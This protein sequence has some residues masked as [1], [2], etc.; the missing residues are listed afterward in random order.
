[1]KKITIGARGSKL[2]LAYVEK[3][4]NLILEKSKDLNDDDFVIKTI[5]TSGD[6]HSD[7]KLSEI[8][9][10]NL[11][12]K[13][14]EENLLEN[15][16][17]IAVHSLKDMESEQNESLMIGAY[18]K[19]NDPRDVL[20]CNKIQNFNELS[21]GAKIGSSSRRRE[22]QLKKINK[23]VSVLNIRGNIDT[24][25]QKIEDQKLDAIVLAAAGVKSLNLENKIGLVF[26]VNEILPAVGQG[27]IAVQCRKDDGPIK[28]TIKKINDTETSLC[29]IAER[30][31]LQ[32]IGGDCETAI[33]GLAEI[34]NNN[35]ILKAQLFSDEGDESFDYKFTGRDVDAANIGK[36]VGE[37]L[38]NLAGKKFKRR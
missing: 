5:K 25:I 6:I 21:K 35:L 11:F 14:I 31:M 26:D 19:R 37:K 22:L 27:I 33:G 32:T 36:T 10:K 24:R 16:I 17:D 2:S 28:D 15:N 13:E 38:L 3:V 12:C 4:K 7:I 1:M 18:V 23:N 29:A 20:I 30:K 34:T 8:G 9:G